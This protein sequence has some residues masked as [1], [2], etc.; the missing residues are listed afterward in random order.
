MSL[1]ELTSA[2]IAKGFVQQVFHHPRHGL[3]FCDLV[4]PSFMTIEGNKK[5]AVNNLTTIWAVHLYPRN[6]R[7]LPDQ[8]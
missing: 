7:L 3:R 1:K 8:L 6:R 2:G 4:Q 5:F